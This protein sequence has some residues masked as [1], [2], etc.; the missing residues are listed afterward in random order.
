[1]S[2]LRFDVPLSFWRH[3]EPTS[4]FV[5]RTRPGELA[6][7][8]TDQARAFLKGRARLGVQTGWHELAEVMLGFEPLPDGSQGLKPRLLFRRVPVDCA[9]FIDQ[10][11]LLADRKVP[12]HER[13]NRGWHPTEEEHTILWAAIQRL[14]DERDEA[15]IGEP[16]IDDRVAEELAAAFMHEPK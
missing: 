7:V 2:V 5:R 16:D 10:D 3:Q 4:V 15:E 8:K 9:G 12:M 14:I 1:M 6:L 13:E 11:A